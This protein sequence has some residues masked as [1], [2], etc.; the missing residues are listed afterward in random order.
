MDLFA[1]PGR[2]FLRHGIEEGLQDLGAAVGDDQADQATRGW[3]DRADD[4]A[5]DVSAVIA[6]G[7]TA[8]PLDPFVAGARSGGSGMGRGR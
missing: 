1:F 2:D 7:G 4:V 6:L 3:L 8:A 5:P